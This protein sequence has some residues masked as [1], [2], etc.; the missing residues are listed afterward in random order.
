ML[1]SLQPTNKYYM[2]IFCNSESFLKLWDWYDQKDSCDEQ[3]HDITLILFTKKL[4][5]SYKHMQG[6]L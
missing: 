4:I 3:V 1:G 5:K 2:K 6:A